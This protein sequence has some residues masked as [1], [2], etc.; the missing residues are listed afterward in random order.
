MRLIMRLTPI[1]IVV[2]D[3]DYLV[4]QG[5][6]RII[7]IHEDLEVV[8]SCGHYDALRQ[9]VAE[10][11]P[12]VVL[13]DIRMPPGMSD[14]GIRVASHLATAA[15]EVGVVVLSQYDEPEY[16]LALLDAG[17]DR[18]SYLLKEKISDVDQ[19]A[20][21]I[22][23]V[24]DGGS[25]IDPKVVERLVAARARGDSP[26]AWLTGRESEVLAA[27]ARG[28]S[29]AAIAAELHIGTRAVE[30]HI[31]SIFAKLG[32]V[33]DDKRHRRVQAVLTFLSEVG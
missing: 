16:V 25:V 7:A 13:T 8:A 24:A 31:N 18:R 32:L 20:A 14:E 29:N 4:R 1:R 5:I 26:L 28:M 17:S 12:D 6:E 21:A 15:P 27:M 33:E 10:H 3:D 11:R 2:G 23:T 19:L 30:K 9:A 22:R